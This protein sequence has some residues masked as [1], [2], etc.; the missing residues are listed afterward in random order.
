MESTSGWSLPSAW[1]P[2]ACAP[3]SNSTSTPSPSLES[4]LPSLRVCLVQSSGQRATLTSTTSTFRLRSVFLPPFVHTSPLRRTAPM[5]VIM[6]VIVAILTLA[7]LTRALI[8]RRHARS[9]RPAGAAPIRT[10]VVMGSGGHT[11]EMLSLLG[12]LDKRKYA[13]L[14]YVFATSDHTSA[15]R[16]AAFEKERAANDGLPQPLAYRMLHIPR[17]REVS[18]IASARAR[19]A[20][21][22]TRSCVGNRIQPCHPLTLALYHH[23]LANRTGLPYQRH[24]MLSFVRLSLSCASA[25]RWCSAMGREPAF[26]S[27]WLRGHSA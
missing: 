25:R 12:G 14:L 23:R 13:P 26:R 15:R 8:V 2:S 17:S 3:P 16:I 27:S 11:A 4:L 5:A 7:W 18:C 6:T 20:R 9:G 19:P 10:L 22:S 21:S 1:S 24:S